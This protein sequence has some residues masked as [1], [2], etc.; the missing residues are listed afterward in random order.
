MSLLDF[1]VEMDNILAID[2]YMVE[3]GLKG[4]SPAYEWDGTSLR[5]E[6]PNGSWGAWVDLKGEKG[7]NSATIFLYQRAASLPVT[8]DLGT[9]TY[10]FATT[11]LS[12]T[13]GA[14]SED[15]TEGDNPLYVIKISVSTHL[16][17]IDILQTDWSVPK[18]LSKD[19]EVSQAEFDAL[20]T[21]ISSVEDKFITT[22]TVT[23][24]EYEFTGA[25]ITNGFLTLNFEE[26]I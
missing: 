6:N 11:A 10:T 4:D 20:E 8:T 18:I 19:G 1:D 16:D 9:L 26:V 3:T 12:G 24:D 15:I 22:D 13:L 5:F 25:T 23:S 2:V 7:N 14:W 21:R 17:T